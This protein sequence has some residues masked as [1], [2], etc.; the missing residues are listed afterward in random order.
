MN[1][2]KY[3]IGVA[4]VIVAGLGWAYWGGWFVNND[5]SRGQNAEGNPPPPGAVRGASAEAVALAA[6]KDLALRLSLAVDKI[7]V[8]ETKKMDWP[9]ACLGLLDK[10]AMC[11]E[12]ITPGFRVTLEANGKTYVYRTNETGLV[13]RLE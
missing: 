11:A 6:Q 10:E 5:S 12:V 9:D 1:T 8:K 4:V 13:L 3:I 7:A 2:N